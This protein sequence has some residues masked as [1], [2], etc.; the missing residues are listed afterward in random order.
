[1]HKELNSAIQ[2]NDHKTLAS[3]VESTLHSN[4][5]SHVTYYRIDLVKYLQLKRSQGS[6]IRKKK[7][8]TT[9]TNRDSVIIR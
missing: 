4:T 6:M 9:I 5:Q 8:N 2:R 7:D 3:R 1:M